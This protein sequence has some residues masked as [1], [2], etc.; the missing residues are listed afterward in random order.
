M[1]GSL[2]AAPLAPLVLVSLLAA[3]VPS[4]GQ[5]AAK[6]GDEAPREITLELV[7]SDPDWLGRA[8]E[9]PYWADDGASVYFSQKQ[10]GEKERDLLRID[11]DGESITDVGD[12]ERGALSVEAT[13]R[14][15]IEYARLEILWLREE[16][17]QLSKP[18]P[19]QAKLDAALDKADKAIAELV[20]G[21]L[22]GTDTSLDAAINKMEAFVNEVEAQARNRKLDASMAEEFLVRA[23]ALIGHLVAARMT[24]LD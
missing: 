12:A 23:E 6:P 9:S 20:S 22:I 21:D 5:E 7:M 2:S 18:K 11:L 4:A 16:V 14:S 17:S 19:L 3:P 10:L 13:K 15:M 1:P 24:P 8:P